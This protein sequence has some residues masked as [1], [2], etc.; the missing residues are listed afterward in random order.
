MPS[1]YEGEAIAVLEQTVSEDEYAA[2]YYAAQSS[3]S[4]WNRREIRAALCVTL[5]VVCASAIPVYRTRFSTLFGPVGGILLFLALAA[6][7]F[8]VQP[9][10]II[11][12]AKRS[13]SSNR[14][15]ALPQK[16]SVYRDSIVA[17]SEKERFTEYW[18]DFSRCLETK[19]AFVLIGG[20]E[21][22]LMTVQKEGLDGKLQEQLSGHFSGAFASRYQKIGR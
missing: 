1:F 2:A 18:T 16:V 8:F 22:A 12:Q 5:A 7:F 11:D 20:R 4:L 21:R 17:V 9:G 13:Y 6:V 14:L 15:L 19:T 10:V 3:A